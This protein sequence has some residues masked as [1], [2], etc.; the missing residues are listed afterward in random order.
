VPFKR[1]IEIAGDEGPRLIVIGIKGRSN[2]ADFILGSTAEK[3]FR[4]CPLPL[5]SVRPADD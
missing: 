4:H 2:L 3:M 5:L 1:Q